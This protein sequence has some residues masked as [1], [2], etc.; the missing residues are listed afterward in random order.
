MAVKLDCPNC[1]RKNVEGKKVLD[2]FSKIC[3]GIGI[4]GAT[5]A[6]WAIAGPFGGLGAAALDKKLMDYLG[7]GDDS[8]YKFQCPSCRYIWEEK[9]MD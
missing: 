3:Y 4:S 5:L 2:G 7:R 6:G 9:C 1:G 8:I